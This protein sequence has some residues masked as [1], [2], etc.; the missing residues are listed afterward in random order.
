MVYCDCLLRSLNH[1]SQGKHWK[2]SIEFHSAP[3]SVFPGFHIQASVFFSD[4]YFSDCPIKEN[5]LTCFMVMFF[6]VSAT[7]K[8]LFYRLGFGQKTGNSYKG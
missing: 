2:S 5:W 6:K 7:V 8:V 1:N 4:D 3:L